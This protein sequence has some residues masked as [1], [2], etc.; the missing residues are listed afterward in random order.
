M[1]SSSSTT[2][3]TRGK[4]P[5]A[6]SISP[7][8]AIIAWILMVFWVLLMGIG[9]ATVIDPN[10]LDFITHTEKTD[11]AM[12]VE[13]AGNDMFYK[14]NFLEAE[15]LFRDALRI[16]PNYGNA[17]IGLGNIYIEYGRIDDA[18]AMFNKSLENNPVLPDLAYGNLGAIYE[19]RGD[20]SRALE[21]YNMAAETAPEATG[22]IISIGRLYMRQEMYDSAVVYFRTA[23]NNLLDMKL[24]YRASMIFAK[25]H[26]SSDSLLVA[27]IERALE[28][29]NFDS[30]LY[31]YDLFHYS[32]VFSPRGIEAY[33]MLGVSLALTKN[34]DEA[35]PFLEY[36]LNIAPNNNVIRSDLN[37]ARQEAAQH[38]NQ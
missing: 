6:R 3:N 23:V 29:D 16:Q 14:G 30:T 28:E 21:Y 22:A 5:S 33:H 35:I 17:M 4:S 15:R 26:R 32:R 27:D 34:F 37:L 19:N 20:K 18:A 2:H 38:M 10:W 13:Q 7:F 25:Q 11:T 24:A 8:Q 1:S 12:M 31:D 36:A 9:I